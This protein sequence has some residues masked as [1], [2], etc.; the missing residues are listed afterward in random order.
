M[1]W[2]DMPH[3]CDSFDGL[4]AENQFKLIG[5]FDQFPLDL[6]TCANANQVGIQFRNT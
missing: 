3:L 4:T 1:D 6:A 2:A 5:K